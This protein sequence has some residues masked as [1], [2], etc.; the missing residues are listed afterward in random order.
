M[1]E[2]LLS[3]KLAFCG[4]HDGDPLA[5]AMACQLFSSCQTKS[6]HWPLQGALIK[7]SEKYELYDIPRL[8]SIC[9][10]LHSLTLL[11]IPR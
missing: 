8:K 2:V 3:F 11:H 10:R 9:G 1:A 5:L 7:T 4:R 6:L